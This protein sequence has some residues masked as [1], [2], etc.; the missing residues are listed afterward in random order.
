MGEFAVGQSPGR[1]E[2]LRLLR[3][4]GRFVEDVAYADTAHG[5]VLRSP[6]AHAAIRS[7]DAAAAHLV[8]GVLAVLTGADYVAEGLGH[9]PLIG[10]PVK[11]RDGSTAYIPPFLPVTPDRARCSGDAVAFVVA[12]T[13][14]AAKDAAELIKVDYEP[15]AAVVEGIDALRPEA[16]TIWDAC[17]DNECFVH[18]V[19]DR[20]ATDSAF[21]AA[22]HVIRQR[23]TISRVLAN[24][25]E[26]RGCIGH[27]D[28]NAGR[29]TLFAP[30]QHPFVARK[31]LAL[32][33]FSCD[34]IN[35]RVV[36]GDIGGS[37]GIKAN[38]YPEYVLAL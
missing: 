19:G 12:E 16:P 26:L 21:K 4:R 11:R 20:A 29:Y 8:P 28:G 18:E 1:L 34:E 15:L 5:F 31:V 7:V 38:I 10:P 3:G 32:T 37:F 23:L 24:A 2:D 6:Y 13:L 30:I 9:I 27:Y 17:P 36:T 25:M 22:D 35:V 14:A 33:I